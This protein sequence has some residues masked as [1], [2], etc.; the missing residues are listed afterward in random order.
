MADLIRRRVAVIVT[1]GNNSASHAAKAATTTIPIVFGV[2]EDPVASGL[3]ASLA[4]PGGNATGINSFVADI[5]ANRAN[6]RCVPKNCFVGMYPYGASTAIRAH[7]LACIFDVSGANNDAAIVRSSLGLRYLFAAVP[8]TAHEW[9]E[10]CSPKV[11]RQVE[12]RDWNRSGRAAKPR[13]TADDLHRHFE[14]TQAKTDASA[15]TW[16]AVDTKLL[17]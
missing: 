6:V 12:I 13:R 5:A 14:P 8:F 2:N 11:T 9:V 7:A 10:R 1:P 3:V 4:R 17:S 16:I 15:C